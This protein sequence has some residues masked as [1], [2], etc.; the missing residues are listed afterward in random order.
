RD[1]DKLQQQINGFT[2]EGQY[3]KGSR[4]SLKREDYSNGLQMQTV[5]LAHK[6]KLE[7]FRSRVN[8]R[9]LT[10]HLLFAQIIILV[11]STDR[12]RRTFFA[13][14]GAIGR[15]SQF[16]LDLCLP[17]DRAEE[18]STA[19]QDTCENK[20]EKR[21]SPRKVALL[22]FVQTISAIYAYHAGRIFKNGGLF[23]VIAEWKKAFAKFWGA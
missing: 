3:L 18:T 12:K 13:D 6:A 2:S 17:P 19:L 21:Y 20:W 15:I 22:C 11:L 8:K 1:L 14:D 5:L 7:E 23:W 4:P 9:S 16:L 10:Y